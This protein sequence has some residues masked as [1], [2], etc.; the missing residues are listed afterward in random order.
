MVMLP[1]MGFVIG[2]LTVLSASCV[3]PV[4]APD[5]DVPAGKRLVNIDFFSCTS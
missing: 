3:L 1:L 4:T 2:L 5:S